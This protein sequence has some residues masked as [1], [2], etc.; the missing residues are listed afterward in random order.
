MERRPILPLGI[1]LVLLGLVALLNP[2]GPMDEG[3]GNTRAE[4]AETPEFL[5]SG[6]GPVPLVA[7]IEPSAA[8]VTDGEG[9]R[10]AARPSKVKTLRPRPA[11]ISTAA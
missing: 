1:G 5:R 7:P 8:P 3:L 9:F 6:R 2:F 4:S 10:P 11:P